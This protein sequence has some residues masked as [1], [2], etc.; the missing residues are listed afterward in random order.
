M[1]LSWFTTIPGL[2]ITGG[3][4]LLLIALVIFI[5][6]SVKGKNKQENTNVN[7]SV[8]SNQPVASVNTNMNNANTTVGVET[9]VVNNT[10]IA[11]YNTA[12]GVDVAQNS[13]TI[14]EVTVTEMNTASPVGVEAVPTEMGVVTPEVGI[15]NEIP[16]AAVETPAPMENVV[17]NDSFAT[18][19]EVEVPQVA[20]YPEEAVNT[21][22]PDVAVT[23]MDVAPSIPVVDTNE[24]YQANADIPVPSVEQVVPEMQDVGAPTISLNNQMPEATPVVE[25]P[26]VETPVV[27]TPVVETPVVTE[28]VVETPVVEQ[29]SIYGGA[30]PAITSYEAPV[31]E[32]QIYGGANPL[33]NTQSVPISDIT[34][35]LNNTIRNEGVAPVVETPT[36]TEPVVETP[37]V[38][39]PVVEAPVMPEVEIPQVDMTAVE[40]PVVETPVVQQ[41][42]IEL[43]PIDGVNN[44]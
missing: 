21:Q 35:G 11:G 34:N 39:T 15:N 28:P 14:P 32:H 31:Y 37:V 22:I 4:I 30:N 8:E 6:T 33:E 3:V 2:L 18:V 10:P 20:V 27:E 5:V 25:A 44:M 43:P 1:S 26:V 23:P 7:T 9:P 36:V 16:T 41:P 24:N 40:T 13:T 38:E 19:P 17:S 29:P 42:S 12:P